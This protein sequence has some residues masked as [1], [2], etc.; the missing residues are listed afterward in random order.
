MAFELMTCHW[1]GY[2]ANKNNY[3]I[4]FDAKDGRAQFLPH[5][6]DQMFGDPDFPILE[7]PQTIVAGKVMESPE[8]RARYKARVRELLPLFDRQ[9]L[10]GKLDSAMARLRPVIHRLSEDHEMAFMDQ[11]RE[12]KERIAARDP[13]LHVLLDRGDPMPL[14]FDDNHEAEIA[15]W[16]GAH[17]TDDALLDMVESDSER[18]Y[19]IEVGESGDCVAS[20]R[21]RVLL[22]QGRYRVELIL[23]TEEVVPRTD[24][25]GVGAGV[26][27]S[28]ERRDN[29]LTGDSNWQAVSYDFEVGD[30]VRLVELVVELRAAKG[31]MWFR[32]PARLLHIADTPGERP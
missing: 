29:Q 8:W 26:R 31:R 1:D 9:R 15:D 22:A 5:G 4:Y 12:L 10:H 3:R 14:A 20:W 18:S 23:K 21:S 6:M 27:I 25:H 17:Q 11:V 7:Y 30:A 28:G 19:L 2:T 13:A 24:E 32:P 16:F